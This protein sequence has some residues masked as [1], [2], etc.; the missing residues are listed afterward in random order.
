[1]SLPYHSP[2]LISDDQRERAINHLQAQYASGV[3]GEAELDRRLGVAL[4][5]RD[6][7]ELNRSL[8]GLARIAPAVLRPTA[9][10]QPSPADNVGGG[11]VQLSGL[12]TSFVGP[13]IVKASSRPGSPIWWEAGRALSLQL[14]ALVAAVTVMIVSE[15]LGIGGGL[16]FLGWLAWLATT[17]WATMRAFNGRP[18]TGALEGLLPFRPKPVPRALSNVR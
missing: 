18:G 16:M 3:I 15:L 4:D 13:A 8:Q 5:A 2:N 1:M 9:P 6:R 14:S 17:I 10:G 7:V 11:L 12:F